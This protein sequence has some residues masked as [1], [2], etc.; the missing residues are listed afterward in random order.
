[1]PVALLPCGLG[2]RVLAAGAP[3]SWMPLSTAGLRVPE[4]AIGVPGP[5]PVALTTTP[6]FPGPFPEGCGLL[7]PLWAT[8]GP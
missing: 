1:M 7:V 8:P 4:L 6:L 2:L 5:F 3:A